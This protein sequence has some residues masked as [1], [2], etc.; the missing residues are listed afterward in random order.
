M[1]RTLKVARSTIHGKGLFAT[2]DIPK[3][4]LIGY[5]KTRRTR[6]PG[7]HTLWLDRGPVDVTCRLRYIN[8]SP[9]PNVA[10]YDDLSVVALKRIRVGDEL[11]HHYGD[12][13]R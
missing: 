6:I 2:V 1:K 10:Y 12:D 13:W 4:T 5:C 9:K 3:G 8:H 11:T 7:D